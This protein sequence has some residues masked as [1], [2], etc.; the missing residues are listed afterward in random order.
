MR[1]S[2]L[3]EV[4]VILLIAIIS[5]QLIISGDI[6]TNPGPKRGGKNYIYSVALECV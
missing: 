4:L 6:E 1:H 3:R 5:Q 2:L